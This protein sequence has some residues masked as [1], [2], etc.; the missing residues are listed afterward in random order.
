MFPADGRRGPGSCAAR[1]HPGQDQPPGRTAAPAGSSGAGRGAPHCFPRP[2]ARAGHPAP[3]PL[4]GLGW[5]GA[6][7][8]MMVPPPRGLSP[9][10]APSLHQCGD[11]S[12][13]LPH[14]WGAQAPSCSGAGP[15]GSTSHSLVRAWGHA[16]DM[17]LCHHPSGQALSRP[18]HPITGGEQCY[19]PLRR[20]L[21]VGGTDTR[22]SHSAL[23]TAPGC[24][25]PLGRGPP[26]PHGHQGSPATRGAG[27]GCFSSI[28]SPVTSP[29]P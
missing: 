11:A 25:C 17:G 18:L 22:V 28:C 12:M 29:S 14:M 7:A 5:S 26:A 8:P 9:P 15:S 21:L 23:L 20:G 4:L 24:W 16:Q 27:S 3:A 19:G 13:A 10:Q 2:A 1:V 6:G